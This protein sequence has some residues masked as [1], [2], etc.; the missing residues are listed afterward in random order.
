M[1]FSALFLASALVASGFPVVTFADPPQTA[2]TAQT[3][4]DNPD[5]IICKQTPPP[6]GSRLGGGRECHTRRQWEQMQKD[7]REVTQD[8]QT[9]DL[10][11]GPQG[12]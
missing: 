2:D 11:L 5:E 3:P 8:R 1:R 4:I 9:R 10:E 6:T 12:H 7:A